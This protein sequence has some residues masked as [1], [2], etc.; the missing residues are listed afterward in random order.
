MQFTLITELEQR[1]QAFEIKCY[2]RQ[3]NI[4]YKDHVTNE[5]IRRKIQAAMGKED[6]PLGTDKETEVQGTL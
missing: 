5:D 1:T 2:R 3:L 6:D 4:S